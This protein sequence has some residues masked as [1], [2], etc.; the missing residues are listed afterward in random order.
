MTEYIEPEDEAEADEE[1]I[2]WS[3]SYNSEHYQL[4]LNEVIHAYD[5]CL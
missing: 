1:D 4:R 3:M 5:R 2:E